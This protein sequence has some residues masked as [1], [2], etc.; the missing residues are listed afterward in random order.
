MIA[1][2]VLDLKD[3]LINNVGVNAE[4]GNKDIDP[5]MYPF[6]KIQL[7]DDFEV[8]RDNTKTLTIDLPLDLAFFAAAS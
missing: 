8:F 2:D 4:F 1:T 5:N 3:Y 6:I 7:V